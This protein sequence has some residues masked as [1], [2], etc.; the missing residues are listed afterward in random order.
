MWSDDSNELARSDDLGLF[1]E[2][3]KMALIA[4]YEVIGASLVG[5]LKENVVPGVARGLDRMGGQYDMS[6]V[7]DKLEKLPAEAFA[8]AQFRARQ[9]HPVF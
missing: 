6:V 7:L 9:D 1:P 3:R 5:T 4:G 8:D 2:C